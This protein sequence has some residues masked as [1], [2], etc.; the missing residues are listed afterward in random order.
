M[1]YSNI[2]YLNNII[3]KNILF[4][5]LETTGLVK[6]KYNLK[7]EFKYPDYNSDEYND[8]RIVSFGY[9][10]INNFNYINIKNYLD[11][12][13]NEF[14]VKPDNFI[15]KNHDIHGITQEYAESNGKNIQ[16][17]FDF[18]DCQIIHVDCIIGYN[19]FFDI[20]ILLSELY[21]Y[22]YKLSIDKIIELK[23]N[24]KIFCTGIVSSF[25]A[26]PD[27]WKKKFPSHIPKQK[28]VYN[29]C[30]GELP[31]NV[32]NSKYDVIALIKI[33]EYIYNNVYLKKSNVGKLWTI[34]EYD[35]LKDEIKKNIP[36]DIICDNHKRNYRGIQMA[37]RKIMININ[38]DSTVIL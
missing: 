1:S 3:G 8:A 33:N 22:G 2:S 38:D 17:Y 26:K 15:I 9:A 5:D 31:S 18:F 23:N 37:I 25:Y 16:E 6:T 12:E 29:K 13:I 20:S 35:Q 21:R 34:Q 4:F 11:N 19:I 27:G 24:K 28:D 32:H 30:F 36:I 10:F 7:P 14:I